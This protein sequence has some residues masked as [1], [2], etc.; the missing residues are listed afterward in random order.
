MTTTTATAE[1]ATPQGMLRL[2][3]KVIVVTGAGRGIGRSHA[4]LLAERGA[5]VV[6]NDLG[7][8][9]DGRTGTA[10]PARDTVAELTG[11]GLDAIADT[12]D[13]STP[14]GAQALIAA[15]LDAFGRIDGV[16]NN[17]GIF[18]P[19]RTLEETT[20]ED[21]EK[22]WRVNLAG[23]YNVS[24]AAWP[25]F[26]AQGSGRIVNTTSLAGIY[27]AATNLDYSA[28]KGAVLAFSLALADEG[29]QHGIGVN[30]IAPGGLTRMMDDSMIEDMR[31]VM[32]ICLRPELVSPVVVWLMHDATTV[33]AGVWEA[34]GGRVARVFTGGPEGLWDIALT[35]ESVAANAA[36]IDDPAGVTYRAGMDEWMQW[37]VGTSFALHSAG[38]EAEQ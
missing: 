15:T 28:A 34:V 24:K 29:R 23:T 14:A 20:L 7:A 18:S 11:D 33:T 30:A 19:T 16:V 5:H 12:N 17:A 3:G 27:G 31:P 8:E 4:R 10:T 6:V 2:D 36:V 22:C 1:S 38:R 13:V 37:E 25:H 9:R 35:P 26:R 21:F 32:E